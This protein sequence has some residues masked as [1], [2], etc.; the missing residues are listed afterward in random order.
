M[1]RLGFGRQVLPP[2]HQVEGLREPADFVILDR[3]LP[4]VDGVK[5]LDYHKLNRIAFRRGL[6]PTRRRNLLK[7]H[8]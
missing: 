7:I 5:V 1:A 2:R 3:N 8:S 4:D 6:F